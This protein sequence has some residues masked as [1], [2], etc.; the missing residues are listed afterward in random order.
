[1]LLSVAKR[2]YPKIAAGQ[3]RGT[4]LF[5]KSLNAGSVTVECAID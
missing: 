2:R 3:T 5:D 4:P 1:M